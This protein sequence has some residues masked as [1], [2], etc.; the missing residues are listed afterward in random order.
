[1]VAELAVVGIIDLQ[2]L[3]ARDGDESW[4]AQGVEVDYAVCGT[5]S[6]DVRKRFQL[7]L[8]K[9]IQ[10][11]F[12]HFGNLGK[13]LKPAPM[14]DWTNLVRSQPQAQEWLYTSVSVHEFV[15]SQRV[16]DIPF[17]RIKYAIAQQAETDHVAH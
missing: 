17:A 6:D 14:D 5:S 9:M 2:V 3:I 10:A 7:G 11:H 1:M 4:V 13:L 15:D 8:G 12:D 16:S